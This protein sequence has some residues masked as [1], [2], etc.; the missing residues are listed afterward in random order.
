MT[1]RVSQWCLL[2][3]VVVWPLALY[4]FMSNHPGTVPPPRPPSSRDRRVVQRTAPPTD[5]RGSRVVVAENSGQRASVF[6]QM[7]EPGHLHVTIEIAPP[8]SGQQDTAETP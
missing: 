2:F 1:I 7:P 8:E 3:G 6:W 5:L 4:L